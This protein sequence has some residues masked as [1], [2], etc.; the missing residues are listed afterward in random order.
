M[1]SFAL[2]SSRNL[3]RGMDQP[4]MASRN[5]S[6]GACTAAASRSLAW[7]AFFDGDPQ[8]LQL[9]PQH[10]VIGAHPS[11]VL[12]VLAQLI[13]ASIGPPGNLAA[14]HFPTPFQLPFNARHGGGPRSCL[15]CA[16]AL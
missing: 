10:A 15:S 5:A 16:I 1:P 4:G 8:H 6:R 13:Q 9:A 12:H 7:M 3:R 14:D 11:D 2:D